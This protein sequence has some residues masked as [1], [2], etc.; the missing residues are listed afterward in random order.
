MESVEMAVKNQPAIP[1]P[2]ASRRM[3]PTSAK[4]VAMDVGQREPFAAAKAATVRSLAS[5]WSAKLGRRYVTRLEPK[6]I[7]AVWRAA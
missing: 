7:I 4:I 5:Y 3:A 1:L 6:G 2:R